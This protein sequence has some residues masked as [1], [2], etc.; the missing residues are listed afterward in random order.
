MS[1]LLGFVRFLSFAVVA[2]TCII[3]YVLLSPIHR[4][5]I[6][7]GFIMRKVFIRIMLVVL[8][9]R[10]RIYGQP[11]PDNFR[12]F[13]VANHRSYFDPVAILNYLDAVTVAKSEV[14]N[15]PI[16]GVGARMVG[17]I[18]VKREVKD[19]RKAAR[20]KMLEVIKQ[21]YNILIFPEG[22]SHTSATMLGVRNATFEMAV[23]NHIP[24]LP[25]AIE[26]EYER[27]AWVGDDTFIRHYLECF[28]KWQTNVGLYFQQPV[29]GNDT[30][31]LKNEVVN[32]INNSVVYMRRELNY[33]SKSN[34]SAGESKSPL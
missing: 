22:T 23:Q 3:V 24:M 13:I 10:I 12:G 11:P 1:K 32:K 15:W 28:G 29:T 7:S 31:E 34:L 26:Y 17:V 18:W 27:D 5:S 2:S 16:V 25:L 33:K 30:E 9:V 8:N 6:P 20:E 21:G 19:S 14:S 4:F